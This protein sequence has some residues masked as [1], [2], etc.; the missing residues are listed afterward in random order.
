MSAKIV[1]LHS[2]KGNIEKFPDTFPENFD[3]SHS[4]AYIFLL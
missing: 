1:R 4:L 3:G 2:R